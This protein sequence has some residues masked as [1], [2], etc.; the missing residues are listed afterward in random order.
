MRAGAAV[1]LVVFGSA[2]DLAGKAWA[3]AALEPYAAP[4]DFLPLVSL[5]LSFNE[6]VS[7]SMFASESE[8]ARLVLLALTGLLTLALGVAALRSQRW[9]RAGL[10]LIV[11]GALGNLIDRAARGSVTDFLGLHFG[12]WYPF[13]FNLADVWISLGVVVLVI[14]PYFSKNSPH[15]LKTVSSSGESAPFPAGK[16]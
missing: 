7:F 11:A 16:P 12:E 5:R 14:S 10:S 8:G 4:L 9:Q 15:A 2:L 6:G 3:R 1:S 13:V